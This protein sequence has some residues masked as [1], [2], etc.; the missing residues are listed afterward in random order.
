VSDFSQQYATEPF[1]FFFFLLLINFGIGAKDADVNVHVFMMTTMM[2]MMMMMGQLLLPLASLSILVVTNLQISRTF[3]F[4]ITNSIVLSLYL[5]IYIDKGFNCCLLAGFF[6]FNTTLIS[7]RGSHFGIWDIGGCSSRSYLCTW[8][9]VLLS[10]SAGTGDAGPT[11]TPVR[12]FAF[13]QSG[14]HHQRR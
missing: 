8:V 12:R 1:A 4:S 10:S 2:M 5:Y 13:L 14:G 11:A 7:V 6:V 9:L 3:R